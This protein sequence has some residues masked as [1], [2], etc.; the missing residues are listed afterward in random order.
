[1]GDTRSVVVSGA[2]SG[3]VNEIVIGPHRIAADEHVEAGGTDTGPDPFELLCSALGACTS[4]TLGVYARRRG[5]PLEAVKV[6]LTY[7]AV[8]PTAG[9]RASTIERAIQ[10]TGELTEEHR[11]KLLEIANKCP[12]HK[13]LSAGVDVS[14]RLI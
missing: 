5:I 9:G 13:A 1:M 12:V 6:T 8:T 7:S 14:S 11:V 3:F 4:M 2:A 10:L